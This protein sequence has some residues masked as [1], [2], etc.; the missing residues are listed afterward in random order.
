M[1][2]ASLAVAVCS[3][4]GCATGMLPPAAE[5]AHPAPI[6]NESIASLYRLEV[7]DRVRIDVFGEPDLSVETTI[8]ATGSITYP[9]L[10]QVPAVGL[11][12]KQ[13]EAS[14]ASELRNGYLVKPDVRVS[15]AQFRPIYVLGQVRRAGSFPY[16]DGLTVEKALALAG[17]LTELA[18]T[19]RI[20]IVREKNA[21][22]RDREKAGLDTLVLPGDTIYV[23]QGLF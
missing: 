14:I 18:S 6:P 8:P 13:L 22:N 20:F 12:P 23:E 11:T 2:A 5:A 21:G 9:L 1:R 15:I 16:S 17:G 7:G 19:R 3:A 4:C 10:G